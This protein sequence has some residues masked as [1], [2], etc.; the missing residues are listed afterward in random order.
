MLG[1]TPM[2]NEHHP[3][4]LQVEADQFASSQDVV[5]SGRS[6]RFLWIGLGFAAFMLV[7]L[8]TP[9]NVLAPKHTTLAFMPSSL[10]R[11]ATPRFSKSLPGAP[12]GIKH[13]TLDVDKRMVVPRMSVSEDPTVDMGNAKAA[14]D[15]SFKKI[16]ETEDM[17]HRFPRTKIQTST[18][19]ELQ[20]MYQTAADAENSPKEVKEEVVI[21][22]E[23]ERFDE[24]KRLVAE[25]AEDD[26]VLVVKYYYKRCTACRAISNRFMKFTKEYAGKKIRFAQLEVIRHKG[27]ARQAGVTLTPSVHFYVDGK[28]AEDFVC[29]PKDIN[30]LKSRLD[31]YN[32]NGIAA[33]AHS[34]M[35]GPGDSPFDTGMAP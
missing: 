35:R 24:F 34:A 3:L 11:G 16:I 29:G 12:I 14:M 32:E 7:G 19:E 27:I 23:I 21:I 13:P 8:L 22:T 4:P 9:A 15:P 25:T 33:V 26:S 5:A 17:A 30:V 20:K 31:D 2:A 28:K 6:T 10:L 18:K 1:K